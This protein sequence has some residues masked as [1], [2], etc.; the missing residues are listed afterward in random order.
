M[1]IAEAEMVV[2][3]LLRLYSVNERLREA[4]R[5]ALILPHCA[6]KFMDSRCQ[7]S[8][9]PS[10]PTY[11]CRGCSEDCLVRRA[12]EMAEAPGYD[13]YVIPGALALRSCCRGVTRQ[14]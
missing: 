1:K 8:F 11:I 14:W 10:V 12:K 7:A 5:R 13:I 3:D 6:R 9:D 2:N 4:F